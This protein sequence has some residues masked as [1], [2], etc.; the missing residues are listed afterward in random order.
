M[1]VGKDCILEKRWRCG[2]HQ[3]GPPPVLE[4][5]A[6]DGLSWLADGMREEGL[7]ILS[8][9]DEQRCVRTAG[10]G[11]G[12]DP[13]NQKSLPLV[14]CRLTAASSNQATNLRSPFIP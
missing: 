11:G 6:P 10:G 13:S 12:G 9:I 2:R 1:D 7:P 4:N 14:S 3:E 5:A 8:E